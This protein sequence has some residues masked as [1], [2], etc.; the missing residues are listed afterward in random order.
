MFACF[1]SLSI[2][3]DSG[4]FENKIY[5]KIDATCSFNSFTICPVCMLHVGLD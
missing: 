4:D 2:S 1:Q 5:V 3:S